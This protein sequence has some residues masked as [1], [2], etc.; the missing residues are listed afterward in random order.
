MS[1]NKDHRINAHKIFIDNVND[2]ANAHCLIESSGEIGENDIHFRKC[3][4]Q[5]EP[6]AAF[7]CDKIQSTDGTTMIDFDGTNHTIDFNSK[8]ANNLNL[9]TITLADK[10]VAT[11][12]IASTNYSG[13]D[14]E[15]ELDQLQGN[16]NAKLSLTG[17]TGSKYLTTSGAGT[18]QFSKS[19][20]DVVD[21]T[22]A[23][24]LT[25]KTMDYNSNTFQNFPAGFS[26]SDDHTFTGTNT[27]NGDVINT[28]EIRVE[29]DMLIDTTEDGRLRWKRSQPFPLTG[30][31]ETYLD[32]TDHQNTGVG[33][34]TLI[35]PSIRVGAT[36]DVLV[37]RETTDTLTNKT[38]TSPV[39]STISNTGTLTLPTSTDTLVGRATT[40]TLT[41]KT[42]DFN[43]NTI[44]NLPS[45]GISASDDI[46][47]TGDC[48]FTSL[49][50][51]QS[52]VTQNG[53]LHI[54]NS[55][56]FDR[57]L[58][59]EGNNGSNAAAVVTGCSRGVNI[60]TNNVSA[61][62]YA[63][64]VASL[65]TT[66]SVDSRN[67]L[68]CRNDGNVG[69]GTTSPA[70]KLDIRDSGTC[71]LN[72]FGGASASY[73]EIRL[74]N[75]NQ[76]SSDPLL[77]VG[78]GQVSSEK[79]CYVTSRFDFPLIFRQNDSER[80]RVH[81]NGYVGIG[82]TTP[83]VPLAV[84]GSNSGVSNSA[85]R[86]FGVNNS[87]LAYDSNIFTDAVSIAATHGILT[88]TY[89]LAASDRRIKKDIV[90]VPDNLALEQ[91]KSIPLRYY[92]YKDPARA[93]DEQ[94]IG[95]IA[96]EV[97]EVFPQ[98]VTATTGF[99]PSELR[100]L[101]NITW[102][103]V[104]DKWSMQCDLEAGTYRFYLTDDNES[105]KMEEVEANED[106]TFTFDKQWN[107]VYCWGKQV[108]DFLTVDKQKLFA[109]NFSATQELAR[110]M[111][112]KDT[113]IAAANEAIA[114]ANQQIA[115]LQSQLTTL[116][117]QVQ[118]VNQQVQTLF[119]LYQ[120]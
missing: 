59:V 7:Q 46:D 12:A 86:Y 117:Q 104:D 88:F 57:T 30:T 3:N 58:S 82:T 63:L 38:L 37:G 43:S 69:I 85:A 33:P 94:V 100:V 87:S 17:N 118:T 32:I 61:S 9:G 65:Q 4:V 51:G 73:A 39:I 114:A 8:T 113:Q 47:F 72:I 28:S 115:D 40:D 66:P 20:S 92:K 18:I 42:I 27:F 31:V 79:V 56:S 35:L 67:I 24:T 75:N 21:L 53:D 36:Q 103:E 108:D 48:S 109:L 76:S 80:M 5:V 45:T 29:G 81:D 74:S 22:T 44:Q 64:N 98:A 54:S 15:Y 112:E 10:S 49:E 68:Y 84:S 77:Y 60:T 93:Q 55:G 2:Q 110:K 6:N 96:Q 41:N 23:Q 91:V 106:G 99:C 105:F 16:I 119:T 97:Q 71:Q 101:E 89:F 83:N 1:V 111:E 19:I 102:T 14:L 52:I 78:T 95:F 107:S 11:T 120:Q 13:Q 70:Y 25:N 116:Q 26:E 90:D 34:F 62:D 50:V